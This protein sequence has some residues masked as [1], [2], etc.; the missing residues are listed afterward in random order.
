MFIFEK[1]RI[2]SACQAGK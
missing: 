1:D 2:C